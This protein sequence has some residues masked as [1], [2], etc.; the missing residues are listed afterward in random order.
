MFPFV[1]FIKEVTTSLYGEFVYNITTVG[2]FG[3]LMDI[4]HVGILLEN[5][6]KY[7][8]GVAMAS[9]IPFFSVIKRFILGSVLEELSKYVDTWF[10]GLVPHSDQMIMIQAWILMNVA[11][12]IIW[13]YFPV[14]MSISMAL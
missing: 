10:L 2:G 11:L 6:V 4:R 1:G 12:W 5:V 7:W 13:L 3:G 8:Y 9:I 14:T